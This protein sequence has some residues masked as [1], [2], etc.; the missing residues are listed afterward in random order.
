MSNQVQPIEACEFEI[1]PVK[2]TSCGDPKMASRHIKPLETCEFEISAQEFQL[3]KFSEIEGAS[4]CEV[5]LEYSTRFLLWCSLSSAILRKT[6]LSGVCPRAIRSY[7]S[8][9]QESRYGM[10]HCTVL[11][12]VLLYF[13]S[14]SFHCIVRCSV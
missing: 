14:Y 1:F 7:N 10:F 11:G 12:S 4:I 8:V 3:G 5:D 9:R 6:F 2:L 13:A